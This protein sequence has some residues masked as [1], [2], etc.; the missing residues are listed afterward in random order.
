MIDTFTLTG[1][2]LTGAVAALIALAGV[3]V[4]VLAL[5]RRRPGSRRPAAALAAGVI[6]LVTGGFVVVTADGGPGTGN[7]IVGGFAAIGL[8]VLAITLGAA[9]RRRTVHVPTP[10]RFRS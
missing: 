4:A 7:G 5:T 10:E 2:R 6:G 1:G 3:A 8:G 9:A